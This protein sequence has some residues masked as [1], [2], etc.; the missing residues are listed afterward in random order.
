MQIPVPST[1]AIPTLLSCRSSPPL[2]K[3][4]QIPPR[5]NPQHELPARIR[6]HSKLLLPAPVH[7]TIKELLQ[8]LQRCI[9]R[10]DLIPSAS[11]PKLEH[12]GFHWVAVLHFPFLKERLEMGDTNVAEERALLGGHGE[13][14]VV[15]LETGHEGVGDGVGGVDGE[16]GWW[17]EVFYCR[18]W[19]GQ[20]EYD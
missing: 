19:E 9:Q 4:L 1:V 18:L 14:R 6:H 16:S 8:L 17:V 15:A 12:R 20:S 7:P 5:R 2:N 13:V 3:A 10:D 11:S